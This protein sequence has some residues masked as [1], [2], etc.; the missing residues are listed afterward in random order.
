MLPL[1][2]N[3]T[4][5]IENLLRTEIILKTV[6]DTIESAQPKLKSSARFVRI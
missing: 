6:R 3:R 2:E 4:V 1:H 5:L